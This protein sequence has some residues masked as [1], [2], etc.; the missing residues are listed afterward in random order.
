MIKLAKIGYF[1]RDYWYIPLFIIG[2]IILFLVTRKSS[3]KP[4]I[5]AK[6][7]KEL[8]VIQ[9]GA[10]ARN[11]AIEKGTEYAV[12]ATKAEYQAK[13]QALDVTQKLE[14]KE[15]ENDPIALARYLERVSR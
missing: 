9:A 4:P 6:V 10:D 12:V 1:L 15:L 13:I 5:I 14:M 8:D 11:I 2:A 3:D 7:K